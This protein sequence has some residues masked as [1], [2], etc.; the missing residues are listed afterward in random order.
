MTIMTFLIA[1]TAASAFQFSLQLY[2]CK[3]IIINDFFEYFLLNT[4]RKYDILKAKDI[5]EKIEM[6]EVI[7]CINDTTAIT[8]LSII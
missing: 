7:V 2:I 8:S 3:S 5:A 1:C 4:G 6:P